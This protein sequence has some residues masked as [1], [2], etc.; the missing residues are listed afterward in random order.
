MADLYRGIMA[1]WRPFTHLKTLPE[2]KK[3][4]TFIEPFFKGMVYFGSHIKGT[5]HL[6]MEAM[7]AGDWNSWSHCAWSQGAGWWMLA[8]SSLLLLKFSL[9]PQPMKWNHSYLGWIFP[10]QYIIHLISSHIL[11]RDYL[12]N[13]VAKIHLAFLSSAMN[14]SQQRPQ[15]SSYAFLYI[16]V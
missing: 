9:G 3:E 8:F 13:S 2:G 12:Q 11:R 14:T 6:G 5:V 7:V 16:H 4:P 1:T 15:K 10:S